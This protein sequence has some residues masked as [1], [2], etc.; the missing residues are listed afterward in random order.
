MYRY[1]IGDT[2]C[3]GCVLA[4]NE[5]TAKIKLREHYGDD[6]PIMVWVDEDISAEIIEVYP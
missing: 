5:D 1:M 4:S 6:E 2:V 3:G